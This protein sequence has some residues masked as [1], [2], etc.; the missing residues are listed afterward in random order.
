MKRLYTKAE[1][2]LLIELYPNTLTAD[3]AD[4]EHNKCADDCRKFLPPL[5]IPGVES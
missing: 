3:D 2:D 4:T 1:I 5:I